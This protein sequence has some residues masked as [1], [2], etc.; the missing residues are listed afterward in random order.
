MTVAHSTS[1]LWDIASSVLNAIGTAVRLDPSG[2]TRVDGRQGAVH[3]LSMTVCL[4]FRLL[5]W[6]GFLGSCSLLVRHHNWGTHGFK[7]LL[8]G[9]ENRIRYI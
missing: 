4:I 8:R 2:E 6:A 9:G 1:I 7:R 5:F 3:L